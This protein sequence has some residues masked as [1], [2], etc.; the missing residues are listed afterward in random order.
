MY[1]YHNI[2]FMRPSEHLYEMELAVRDYELDLQGIVN[3]SVYQN[4]FEHARHEYLYS[5]NIDFAGLHAEGKDLIVHRIEIDYKHSLH[6]HDR[7]R[8]TVDVE[9]EG[10]L[11]IVFVQSIYRVPDDKLIAKA[12]VYGACLLQGRPVK[13][14]TI[15]DPGQLGL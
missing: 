4:Y 7:F 10:H 6:S 15:F 1:F 3:N 12:R 9:R 11:K 5:R 2:C 8:V 13:P 14:E